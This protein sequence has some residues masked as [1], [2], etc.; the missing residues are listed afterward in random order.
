MKE[1]NRLKSRVTGE[2]IVVDLEEMLRGTTESIPLKDGDDF[3][4]EGQYVG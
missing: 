4:T 2:K 1:T 3:V